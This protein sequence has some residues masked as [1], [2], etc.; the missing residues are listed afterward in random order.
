MLVEID[1]ETREPYLTKENGVMVPCFQILKALCGM[2]VSSLLFHRKLRKD[3]EQLGSKVNPYGICV[4]NK[5]I[6]GKQFAVLWHVDDFKISRKVKKAVDQFIEWIIKK[7]EDSE[8]TK[9]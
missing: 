5:M 3:L 4:A 9:V 2:M 1:H 8:I 7:H 6:C